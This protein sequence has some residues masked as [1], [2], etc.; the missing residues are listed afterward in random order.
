MLLCIRGDVGFSKL[1]ETDARGC[2]KGESANFFPADV[3]GLHF[4][5][6]QPKRD[7]CGKSWQSTPGRNLRLLSLRPG[8]VDI[9]I[10]LVDGAV[11][12]SA[13]CALPFNP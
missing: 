12:R 5:T 8:N 4:R 13:T 10:S 1:H 7:L 6:R 11:V 3:I 2:W 9:P